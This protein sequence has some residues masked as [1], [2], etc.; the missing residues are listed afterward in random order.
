MAFNILD[1]LNSI[2]DSISSI[3]ESLMGIGFNDFRTDRKRIIDTVQNF[4][5][6]IDQVRELPDSFQN[7][8]NEI[9]WD[10]IESFFANIVH[11]ELGIDEKEVWNVAKH[12]LRTL[13]KSIDNIIDK[14][15]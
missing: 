9:A 7:E 6:I 10:E 1:T 4:E 15:N 12:K 13:R 11:G 3:E 14:Y 8:N 2:R 5:I